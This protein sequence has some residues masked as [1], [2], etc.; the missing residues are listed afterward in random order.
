MKP[1]ETG[2]V[3]TTSP[4]AVRIMRA[5]NSHDRSPFTSSP[6]TTRSACVARVD[7]GCGAV[8]VSTRMF[9]IFANPSVR[10]AVTFA[11]V[12]ATWL[13]LPAPAIGITT[14]VGRGRPNTIS[15]LTIGAA[16]ASP[17][18][19]PSP[20]TAAS[21][22]G[23]R[24]PNGRHGLANPAPRPS[25]GAGGRL[26]ACCGRRQGGLRLGAVRLDRHLGLEAI[27]AAGHQ[28][29]HLP[30]IVA[31]RGPNLADALEQAVLGDM[32]VRPDRLDQFLL[33]EDSS[34]AGGKQ[35]QHV[36]GSAAAA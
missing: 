13:S 26:R 8:G 23:P 22:A 33:A 6:F 2:A 29:D 34:G 15:W 19:T 5:R 9:S 4:V 24:Q 31:Q 3:H 17:K 27:A 25:G 36:E 12:S 35:H 14:M 7:A 20:A 21:A 32:D 28:P 30:S 18:I 10:R 1:T 11:A 16:T